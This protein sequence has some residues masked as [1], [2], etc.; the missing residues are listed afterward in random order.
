MASLKSA[1]AT[2]DEHVIAGVYFIESE[3]VFTYILQVKDRSGRYGGFFLAAPLVTAREAEAALRSDLKIIETGEK[4]APE[5][6]PAKGGVDLFQSGLVIDPNLKFLNLRDSQNSSATRAAIAEV[7]RWY[8]DLDG[9]FVKDFQSSGID[10]RVWELYLFAAFTEMGFTFDQSNSVPD[11][12]LSRGGKKVFIEAVTANPSNG[13]QFDIAGPPPPPPDDFAGYIENDMPQKFG[14][15]LRSKVKKK[16]WEAS[17]VA[18]HPFVLAIADFHAPASMTWSQTA[19]SFYLYGIGVELRKEHPNYK[20]A[21]EK[22][23]GDHVVGAKVV[24][25]NF[26]GQEEH[27]NVSAILF[28]NAGTLAKFNRMGVLAGF[29]DPRVQLRRIGGLYNY[30][31]GAV[32]PVSFEINVEDP[33]YEE[34]WSDEIEIYHNPDALVP[35]EHELFPTATHF[36]MK[37]GELLWH[38]PERRVLY[39]FTQSI[40]VNRPGRAE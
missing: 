16:Y 15:P 8:D 14:S 3:E 19:L 30:Q 20:K 24:P 29:G 23:L 9:N 13:K 34:A 40:E 27:R 36:Y 35:L 22:K 33:D 12:R 31:P 5:L 2:D 32:D 25:T 4:P 7:A 10:G 18:G 39:S 11:F 17:D 26:F 6:E 28:S 1:W 21:V 38:G 37:E